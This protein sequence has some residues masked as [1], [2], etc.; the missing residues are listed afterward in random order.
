MMDQILYHV[1]V[2]AVCGV[3]GFA[4]GNAAAAIATADAATAQ[5]ASA[6]AD[7]AQ[8]RTYRSVAQKQ[9]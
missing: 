7:A 8:V 2:W 4:V 5:A 3:A 6:K 9:G 1:I